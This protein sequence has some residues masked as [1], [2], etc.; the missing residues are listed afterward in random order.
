MRRWEDPLLVQEGPIPDQSIIGDLFK[1]PSLWMTGGL[2]RYDC[3]MAV[4]E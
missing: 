2:S 1:P 3:K 4:Q